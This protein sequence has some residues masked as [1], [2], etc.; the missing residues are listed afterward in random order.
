MRHPYPLKPLAALRLR[1]ARA[2]EME[3]AHLIGFADVPPGAV[4]KRRVGALALSV[5]GAAAGLI[6]AVLD[7]GLGYVAGELARS[8]FLEYVGASDSEA[9][10][11]RKEV[12]W[13]LGE[14]ARLAAEE[15]EDGVIPRVLRDAVAAKQVSE[16]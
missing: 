8:D 6:A 5:A 12:A 16:G 2:L 14:L 7:W 11:I 9:A 1:L 4:R 10:K 15:G 3:P 13:T